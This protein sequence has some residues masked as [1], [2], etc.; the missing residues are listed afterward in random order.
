M[1]KTK[2]KGDEKMDCLIRKKVVLG[3]LVAIFVIVGLASPTIAQ[4]SQDAVLILHFD[5]GSGTTVKDE[6]GHGNDGTVYGA[7]WTTG[8]SG[9]ALN[10]DG[11]DDYVDIPDSDSFDDLSEFS[12]SLWINMDENDPRDWPVIIGRQ[13]NNNQGLWCFQDQH[14]HHLGL[15]IG[16]GATNT[17]G[18]TKFLTVPINEWHFVTFA[19]DGTIMRNYIDGKYKHSHIPLINYL[20]SKTNFYIGGRH[21]GY[22]N[23]SIDEVAIWNR[24]LSPE[25]IEAHYLAKRAG[26][27]IKNSAQ[28]ESNNTKSVSPAIA[29]ESTDTVLILHF[30]E[31]S[32]SVAK[33]ESG[34]GNDGTI[35]GATWTTGISGNALGF[36]GEKVSYVG[37]PTSSS[38]DIRSAMTISAWINPSKV[39]SY[40]RIVAKPHTEFASPHNIYSLIF[41]NA[42]HARFEGCIGEHKTG[43]NGISI[44]P[45][46]EWTHVAATYDGSQLKLYVNG[47]LEGTK[48]VTE[49]ICANIMPLYIGSN[50][51]FSGEN[52]NGAIDEVAIYSRALTSEEIKAH[53]L[54]KRAGGSI[55]ESAQSEI[56]DAKYINPEVNEAENKSNKEN[57]SGMLI[58]I[59]MFAMV[60]LFVLAYFIIKKSDGGR[61]K[62]D[63]S[64]VST[65]KSHTP[66]KEK[67]EEENGVLEDEDI[68]YEVLELVGLVKKWSGLSDN[69]KIQVLKKSSFN[70]WAKVESEP[71]CGVAHF[72]LG[73][74]ARMLNDLDDA[75]KEFELAL[76]DNSHELYP[77]YSELAL[78]GLN[79][80]RQE[81]KHCSVKQAIDAKMK[82][83]MFKM[84]Y[85]KEKKENEE[86]SEERGVGEIQKYVDNCTTLQYS[87][88]VDERVWDSVPEIHDLG[89]GSKLSGDEKKK[90]AESLVSK[91]PDLDYLYSWRAIFYKR[92]EYYDKAKT[93]LIEG[94]KISKRKYNLYMELGE[95]EY[96]SNN[97]LE[98]VR[99]WIQSIL[100]QKSIGMTDRASYNSFLY[101]AYICK[102]LDLS[103]I[104]LELLKE[105]DSRAY[106]QIRLTDIEAN[107]IYS[108]VDQEEKSE[109]IRKALSALYDRL[110]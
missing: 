85:D 80:A 18:D 45:L 90:L 26:G 38:L 59:I 48:D 75:I 69:E 78:I 29:Q 52:F 11:V 53:Y 70:L 33:D 25:E 13:K 71:S 88:I 68:M 91:Y 23:G 89:D 47:N 73:L 93:V 44:I 76:Q 99:W 42:G 97:L 92:E 95:T 10:F 51:F 28:S 98:A 43:I 64:E 34:H 56:D 79:G 22:F 101:L 108:L 58:F 40:D 30:D 49:K 55:K 77:A 50:V 100:S 102:R 41:D 32:G 35:Y 12:V 1:A 46:N 57:S 2:I 5:E 109:F 96:Y 83:E 37:I 9:K 94:L 103:H 24:V 84:A 87:E 19:F 14:T 21:S 27:S 65:I 104:E 72:G 82:Y 39:T 16:D 54:A 66:N 67:Q 61:K 20:N 86:K 81:K 6:S 4:A 107:N 110:Y 7:T 60:G 3:V 74:L 31:G 105:V 106:G 17:G 62:K 36:T 15:N 8:I 63:I